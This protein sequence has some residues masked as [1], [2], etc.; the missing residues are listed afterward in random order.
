MAQ[1]QTNGKVIYK[2][3]Y[4]ILYIYNIVVYTV[5]IYIYM[6]V[7]QALCVYNV[8]INQSDQIRVVLLKVMSL[9]IILEPSEPLKATT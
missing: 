1:W 9:D 4:I 6:Y 3:I 5:C 8:H 7:Y 2:Y